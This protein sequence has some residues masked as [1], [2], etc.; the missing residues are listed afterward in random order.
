MSRQNIEQL[1]R[2]LESRDIRIKLVDTRLHVSAP[3][4]GMPAE[5]RDELGA[6]KQEIVDF[7][8]AVKSDETSAIPELVAVNDKS[9]APLSFGQQRIWLLHELSKEQA[10][11][12][13]TLTFNLRIQGDLSIAALRH[14]LTQIYRRHQILRTIVAYENEQPVQRVLADEELVLDIKSLAGDSDKDRNEYLEQILADARDT[15][16]DPATG[17]L[18]QVQLVELAE[19]DHLLVFIIH[20][21]VFDA[22]SLAILTRELMQLYEG[23]LQGDK[24]P[25]PEPTLQY[26][27]FARWQRDWLQGDELNRYLNYWKNKLDGI[28]TLELPLDHIRP[29]IQ[30]YNGNTQGMQLSRELADKLSKLGHKNDASL[31]MTMLTTLGLFLSRY[32]GQSDIAIGTPATSRDR[33]E[34][35]DLIGFFLNTL[36]I[37]LDYSG[38]V[39]FL[40]CLSRCR[41]TCLEAF[42]HQH[43]PFEKLVEEFQLERDQS[44]TPLFQVMFWLDGTPDSKPVKLSNLE[45]SSI[46]Q[47][48][49]TTRFDLDVSVVETSEG[50]HIGFTYNTDLFSEQTIRRMLGHYK[51]LLESIVSEPDQPTFGL[52]MLDSQEQDSIL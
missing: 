51:T 31:F 9:S 2:E 24:Q 42:A 13:D 6:R 20:H 48:G 23:F 28:E 44:S 52:P 8:S 7:L 27:D 14:S 34:L 16:L 4:Q 36:V 40:I 41:Q 35:Q 15:L 49:N 22:W 26:S 11:A 39:D 38:E 50:F 18:F 46:A 33:S 21:M 47:S 43:L 19:N 37:R 17:P 10:S 30:T 3:R 25:L 1:F 12:Y 29:A 45:F 5:L 32:T